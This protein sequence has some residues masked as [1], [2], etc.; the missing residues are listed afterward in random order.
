MGVDSIFKWF[1]GAKDV[2]RTWFSVITRGSQA[3]QRI[4]LENSSVLFYSLKFMLYVA[5]VDLVLHLPLAAVTRG[6]G[7]AVS[8][9][10]LLL[11]ETYLEYLIL[12][13]ALYGAMRVV[14]GKGSLQ[15]SIAAYCFLTAYLPIVSVLMMPTRALIFPRMEQHPD[16]PTVIEQSRPKLAQLSAWEATGFWLSFVLTT[17]VFVIFFVAIFQTFRMLHNLSNTRAIVGFLLGL[18]SAAAV[19]ALFVEPF[20]TSIFQ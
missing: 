11:L 15:A 8:I 9:E 13:F 19:L 18:I 5:F 7:K 14:G 10:S 20:L 3:F 4:D 17:L 16:L 12:G 2:V 1:D 6:T